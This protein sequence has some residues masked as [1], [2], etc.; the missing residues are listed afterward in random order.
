MN[1]S[2]FLLPVST[3]Y[4]LMRLDTGTLMYMRAP[5]RVGHNE[6]RTIYIPITR[7]GRIGTRR[8]YTE[9]LRVTIYDIELLR[10]TVLT[11]LIIIVFPSARLT[12]RE[13]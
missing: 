7:Y 10:A 12:G 11:L 13:P 1:I 9:Y 8:V 3:A 5:I 2:L 4:D 6:A